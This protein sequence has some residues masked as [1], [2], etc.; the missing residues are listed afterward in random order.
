MENKEIN[1]ENVQNNNTV[2]QPQANFSQIF[3]VESEEQQVAQTPVEEQP[4]QAP[5]RHIQS[6][7]NGQEEVLH[8][9]EEEKDGNP[10][11]PVALIGALIA[12]IL[13]LPYISKR[14]EY[15]VFAP[16]KNPTQQGTETKEDE[17]YEFNKSSVRAKIGTLELTNF[18]KS[19]EYDDYLLSFTVN[20]IGE[21]S[22]DFSKKYYIVLYD[23]T[24]I[25]Y[26]ALIHS[27]DGLGA[28]SATT[29]SVKISKNAFDNAKKFKIEEIPTASYPVVKTTNV[30]GDYEVLTCTYNN[31]EIK[32][33]FNNGELHKIYDEH[34]ELKEGNERYNNNLELYRNSS[35]K[36][37]QVEGLSSI[38]IETDTDFRMINEMELKNI[39]NVT[40]TQLRTYRFFKYKESIKIVS[41]ELE[42][43][44]YNCG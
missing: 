36:Y 44:G 23:G 43:Q 7:F 28:L 27:Y 6:T 13:F 21:K 20:N 1:N 8:T 14:I 29:L 35:E 16:T 32:Y 17:L 25:I 3:N 38:F 2:E 31:S 5:R 26:R 9:I 34:N 42:A 24:K 22:Y 40:M 41:F 33:Y 18:V 19:H 37:K 11:V 30:E 10:L 12:V 4:E 15:N 39:S